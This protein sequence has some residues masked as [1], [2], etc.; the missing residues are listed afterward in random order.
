[1]PVPYKLLA[2]K[3]ESDE[4]SPV[5]YH[6]LNGKLN[7]AFEVYKNIRPGRKMP[8]FAF[9]CIRFVERFTANL[10]AGENVDK[11]IPSGNSYIY[12]P[13]EHLINHVY[14]LQRQIFDIYSVVQTDL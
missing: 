2:N 5:F 14:G 10:V 11:Y 1:M 8:D 6:I 9:L 12:P 3:K 7:A 4:F 13:P